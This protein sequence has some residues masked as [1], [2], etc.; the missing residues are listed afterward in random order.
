[1]GKTRNNYL[2]KEYIDDE[3]LT[4]Y[5]NDYDMS[6][7]ED[8]DDD[9]HYFVPCYERCE[10]YTESI[11]MSNAQEKKSAT[12]WDGT[13]NKGVPSLYKL[14]LAALPPKTRMKLAKF[15]YP[16]TLFE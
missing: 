9:S 16:D 1:M 2:V 10:E 3:E 4:V 7:R 13:L 6:K 14:A 8:Y 5:D 15:A 12:K 11:P